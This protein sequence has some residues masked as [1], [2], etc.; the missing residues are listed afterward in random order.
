MDL[1][2]ENGNKGF[3]MEVLESKYGGWRG[4]KEKKDNNSK[5]LR[6]V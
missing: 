3:W 2:P 5:V 6:K 1:A 4:L